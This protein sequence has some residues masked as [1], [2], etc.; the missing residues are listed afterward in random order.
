MVTQVENQHNWDP[1]YTILILKYACVLL[2]VTYRVRRCPRPSPDPFLPIG[3]VTGQQGLNAATY[4][5]PSQG[6][7]NTTATQILPL[8]GTHQKSSS[9]A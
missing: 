9:V 3:F 2:K 6:P 5:A 7:T 1:K 4:S 8:H